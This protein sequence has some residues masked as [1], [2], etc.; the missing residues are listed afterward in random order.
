M[1][2]YGGTCQDMEEYEEICV[3][4]HMFLNMAVYLFRNMADHGKTSQNMCSGTLKS[5]AEHCVIYVLGHVQT[6]EKLVEYALRNIAE[7]GG[8]WPN[9]CS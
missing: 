3:S 6:M 5:I 8:T 7:H 2:E 9:M 1:A 4:E